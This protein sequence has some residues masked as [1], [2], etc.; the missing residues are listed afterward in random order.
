[1]MLS[2]SP[3]TSKTVLK[4]EAIVKF[5]DDWH[6]V[7]I[8]SDGDD[9]IK[10]IKAYREVERSAKNDPYY[11]DAMLD[12]LGYTS[13]LSRIKDLE[14]AE[15]VERLK[16]S[17]TSLPARL[18][19]ARRYHLDKLRNFSAELIAGI[20]DNQAME[21]HL[22]RSENLFEAAAQSDVYDALCYRVTGINEHLTDAS[23]EAKL[24]DLKEYLEREVERRGQQRAR[25]TSFTSNLME[26]CLRVAWAKTLDRWHT[27]EI[28]RAL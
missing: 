25:S 9:V 2:K 21:Y 17:W 16:R 4:Q 11:H 23:P 5:K 20:A 15:R 27:I 6:K 14:P 3:R 22:G 10:Q 28:G 12:H 13:V 24:K 19:E 7:K 8:T 1:M 18:E 26:E